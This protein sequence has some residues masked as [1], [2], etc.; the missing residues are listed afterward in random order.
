MPLSS[1]GARDWASKS[2]VFQQALGE[3]SRGLARDPNKTTN[4]EVHMNRIAAIA[5]FAGATLMT[6][7]SATAQSNAVEV[8]VPFNFTVNNTFLPAGSYTLGFDPLFP[9]ELI[10]RDRAKN[11]KAT[12][13][14]QRGSLG[15]W[16]PGSLIFHQY[17]GQYFLSAVRVDSGSNGV[18]LPATKLEEQARKESQKEDLAFIAVNR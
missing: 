12:V 6:A 9:D 16:R 7:S 13:F 11:V 4:E 5:L 2:I 1:A 3:G 17:G 15:P 18:F 10:V 14:G 8:N